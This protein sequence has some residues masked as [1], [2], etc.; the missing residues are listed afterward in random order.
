MTFE[1]DFPELLARLFDHRRG[2][3]FVANALLAPDA[4][5]FS[6]RARVE[7]QSCWLGDALRI[8]AT[9][10]DHSLLAAA[11]PIKVEPFLEAPGFE[12]QQRQVPLRAAFH[13]VRLAP[14]LDRA[15]QMRNAL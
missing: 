8:L 15:L 14:E 4:Q 3:Q 12:V 10:T 2:H 7:L 1:D 11:E 6:F 5:R 13:V 9:G